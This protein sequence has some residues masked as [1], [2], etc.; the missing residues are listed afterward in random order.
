[1]RVRDWIENMRYGDSA[2]MN[3]IIVKNFNEEAYQR[4]VDQFQEREAEKRVRGE[5]RGKRGRKRS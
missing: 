5:E 4:K 2:I 3:L 1:M